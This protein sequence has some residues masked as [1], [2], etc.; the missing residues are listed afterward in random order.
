MRPKRHVTRARP[1]QHTSGDRPT[2]YTKDGRTTLYTTRA[3][4]RRSVRRLAL[5]VIGGAIALFVA[6]QFI[7]YG[8]A[9]SD[10]A[11]TNPFT[12]TSSQAEAIARTACY[13]CHSNQTKYWWGIEIAPFSWLAQ[14]DVTRG[15]SWLNFSDWTGVVTAQQM[16]RALTGTMPPF[17]YTL[18]HP[19]ARLSAAQKAQLL[20]GFS[21]SLAANQ[22]NGGASNASAGTSGG[23]TSTGSSGSAT[24]SGVVSI[25]DSQ[26]GTCHGAP[27]G[28]RVASAAQAQALIDQMV[29]QG[30][31]V[32][33]AQ[34]Q[35]L[36]AYFTR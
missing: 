19:S 12:W 31:S 36:I 3:P 7:P 32:T 33:P 9:H 8:H 27:I 25:L 28:M 4:R 35:A 29:Q 17:G 13:D 2:R 20:A 18:M 22:V 21:S 10:P 34:E 5:W 30:A 11:A 6:I 14:R 1:A 24:S 15:R 26:C 16:R 23:G